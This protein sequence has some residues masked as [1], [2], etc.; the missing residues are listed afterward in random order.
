[1]EISVVIPIYNVEEYAAQCLD[2]VLNQTMTD[3]EILCV[4][5]GS[6]DGSMQIIEQYVKRNSKIR[7]LKHTC[8]RGL[9]A[10]RNTGIEN[11]QGKYI[12]FLDSDDMIIPE[13]LEE[14][15]ECAEKTN[16][17]IIYF[18]MKKIYGDEI[19]EARNKQHLNYENPGEIYT[20]KE[21]FC[22]FTEEKNIKFAA[23]RQFYRKD[24]LS[25]NHIYFREGILHEDDLFSFICAMNAKRVINIEKEYY[26]Y[27]QRDGS[28]MS[29]V[30]EKRLKSKFILAVEIFKYWHS[31][32]FSDRMNQALAYYFQE[33]L[34]D[35][36]YEK[37]WFVS[38]ENPNAGNCA[39]NYL[40][41]LITGGIKRYAD[42]SEKKIEL[43]KNAQEVIVFGAGRA[44]NNIIE[45]L[46]REKIEIVAVAVSDKKHLAK[47]CR[48]I[49][50]KEIGD[51]LSYRNTAVVVVGVTE[52]YQKEVEVLLTEMGFTDLVIIDK[53]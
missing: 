47:T 38:Y 53:P 17:D 24:F 2:S 46:Q 31:Q 15:L 51:L 32:H 8:N 1:M 12:Y 5:D 20:G 33:L 34:L 16:A 52:F 43:L 7:I 26:L 42:L 37:D 3:Y 49:E 45:I 40:Y 6:T 50:I 9:S 19:G 21:M 28:I 4:D 23:W 35:F 18:N 27:R 10:A 11:A 25:E 39:E 36:L 13:T 22:I 30:S 29:T 44:A 41:G 48:G 14:L